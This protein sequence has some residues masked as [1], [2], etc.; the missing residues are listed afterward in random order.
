MPLILLGL[1]TK[2]LG[3]KK[4][5]LFGWNLGVS[6]QARIM[7]EGFTRA[8]KMRMDLMKRL[9]V[10]VTLTVVVVRYQVVQ[11]RSLSSTIIKTFAGLQPQAAGSA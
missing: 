3:R 2:Y 11:G 4:S 8:G 9:S 7:L 10:G 6:K 1:T 5:C